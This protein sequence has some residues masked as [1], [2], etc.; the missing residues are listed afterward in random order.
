MSLAQTVLP[1]V[2]VKW[3]GVTLCLRASGHWHE[4][5]CGSHT[6]HVVRPH[7]ARRGGRCLHTHAPVS[8]PVDLPRD[9][10]PA[11]PIR[12]GREQGHQ[13]GVPRSGAILPE[14]M[15]DAQGVDE[16]AGTGA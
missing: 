5:G 13:G 8:S 10:G 4:D 16:P 1:K 15:E 3:T 7:M 11:L 6:P 14:R 2:K 12:A 9:L